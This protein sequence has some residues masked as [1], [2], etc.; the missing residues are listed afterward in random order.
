MMPR[1]RKESNIYWG[2][3]IL[4]WFKCLQ[5]HDLTS[6]DYKVLFYLCQRM[7]IADNMVYVR[8]KQIAEDLKMDKGNI[9][10]CIKKIC[11]KQFIVKAKNGFMINPHLFYVGKSHFGSREELRDTFE[12]L[13]EDN[14]LEPLFFLN[15]DENKLEMNE[16]NQ[17]S[18]S[19]YDFPF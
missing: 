2:A 3:F 6:S 10:K 1:R 14:K 12:D 5:D 18:K 7:N 8:Q 11:G 19:N 4:D 9:S 17:R 13:L 16:Q 15:E